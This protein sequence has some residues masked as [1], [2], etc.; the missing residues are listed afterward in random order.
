MLR[1]SAELYARDRKSQFCYLR[2]L[3]RV[4]QPRRRQVMRSLTQ[5]MLPIISMISA[6]L[7]CASAQMMRKSQRTAQVLV[8]QSTRSVGRPNDSLTN[9]MLPHIY[10]LQCT[11]RQLPA[12]TQAQPY[13]LHE[14]REGTT[15]V[16]RKG[17]YCVSYCSSARIRIIF[18]ESYSPFDILTS[19]TATWTSS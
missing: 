12:L 11:L 17:A 5:G 4:L 3:A 2:P 19:V 14:H 8:R 15:L 6:P 16:C 13:Q 7:G 9:I 10:L 18:H 1:A